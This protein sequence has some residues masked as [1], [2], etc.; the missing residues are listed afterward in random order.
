MGCQWKIVP[1]SESGGETRRTPGAL[2]GWERLGSRGAFGVTLSGPSGVDGNVAIGPKGFFE[3]SGSTVVTGDV[4]LDSGAIYHPSGTATS[5]GVVHTDLS[6]Q[7]NDA[8]AKSADAD[9]L[10]PPGSSFVTLNKKPARAGSDFSLLEPGPTRPQ[11]RFGLAA[12]DPFIL[13]SSRQPTRQSRHSKTSCVAADHGT[14][15]RN[16]PR[17]AANSA[18]S[19][20]T[21]KPAVQTAK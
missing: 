18:D 6:V 5:S 2:R 20:I 15:L 7:I 12:Q 8:I 13:A 16:I 14:P 10:C 21:L 9:A 4:L 17:T 19:S 3:Q 1:P 11:C